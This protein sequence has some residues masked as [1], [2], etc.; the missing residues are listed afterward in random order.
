MD[1]NK[2]MNL[3][4]ILTAEFMGIHYKFQ[5]LWDIQNSFLDGLIEQSVN[6]R[7]RR[8]MFSQI[9]KLQCV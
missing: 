4:M 8:S 5:I 1:Q 3:P 7:R 6:N 2:V 9:D